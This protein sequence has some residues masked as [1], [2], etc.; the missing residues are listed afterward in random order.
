MYVG[1]IDPFETDF[2]DG[3]QAFKEYWWPLLFEAMQP[4]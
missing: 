4:T 1:T 2:D 3:R